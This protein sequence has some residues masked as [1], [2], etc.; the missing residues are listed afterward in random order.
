MCTYH[1]IICY[2]CGIKIV[3]INIFKCYSKR[4]FMLYDDYYYQQKN[5]RNHIII[6]KIF[7]SLFSI[8]NKCKICKDKCGIKLIE[9]EYEVERR[10]YKQ[11]KICKDKITFFERVLKMF[12]NKN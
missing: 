7:E 2:C 8:C 6:I 9:I 5:D 4:E 10:K 12:T 1:H 11:P 3:A